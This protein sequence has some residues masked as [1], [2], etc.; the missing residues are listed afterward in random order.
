MFSYTHQGHIILTGF[1]HGEEHRKVLCA[2]IVL[3]VSPSTAMPTVVSQRS[4]VT[5]IPGEEPAAALR[6]PEP[7]Y[8]RLQVPAREG[9]AQDL[10]LGLAMRD[11][12]HSPDSAAEA[13]K[14]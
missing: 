10:S 13:G 5:H 2:L 14:K 1:F 11:G 7:W 4:M 3:Q 8:H 9:A 12:N 6:H